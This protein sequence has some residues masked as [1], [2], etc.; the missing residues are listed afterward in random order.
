MAKPVLHRIQIV[1]AIALGIPF[2][3]IGLEHFIRP[4]PFDAIVPAYLG[5][6]RFWTLAS[7]VVEVLL[8]IGIMLPPWRRWAALFLAVFLVCVYPANLNMWLN[9][10]PFNGQVLSHKAHVLRLFIQLL[11]ICLALWLADWRKGAASKATVISNE[12]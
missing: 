5:F 2:I 4:A 10:I 12:D 11:L 7:G 1:L 6:P 8:G 9:D 3:M